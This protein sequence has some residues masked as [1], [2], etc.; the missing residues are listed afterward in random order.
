MKL[1]APTMNAAP[2]SGRRAA[3]PRVSRV[4]VAPIRASASPTA[5]NRMTFDRA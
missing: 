1:S 3:S 2:A 5:P 4:T